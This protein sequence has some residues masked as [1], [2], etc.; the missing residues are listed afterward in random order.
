MKIS[1]LMAKDAHRFVLLSLY[2]SFH[3]KARETILAQ[4]L[5]RMHLLVR[6]EHKLR[7]PVINF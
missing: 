3:F 7:R 5:I 6:H 2:S 4:L 1:T